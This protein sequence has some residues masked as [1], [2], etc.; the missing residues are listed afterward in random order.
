ME[1][2]RTEQLKTLNL[3]DKKHKMY[4]EFDYD[5]DV[6]GYTS[7]FDIGDDI[8][9]TQFLEASDEEFDTFIR[10]I[11]TAREEKRK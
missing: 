6:C 3:S 11:Q 7:N 5:G 4:I 2:K 8:D 1:V 10:F 9:L